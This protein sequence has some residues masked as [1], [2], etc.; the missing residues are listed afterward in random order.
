M[1][2]RFLIFSFVIFSGILLVLIR[3]WHLQVQSK[4]LFEEQALKN[5]LRTFPIPARRGVITDRYGRVLANNRSTFSVKLMDPSLPVTH[6]QLNLLATILGDTVDELK[7]KF[8][9]IK[10][11]IFIPSS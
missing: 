4:G 5:Q 9:N 10:V 3:C 2:Y 8:K 7:K 11:N 1:R 6:R